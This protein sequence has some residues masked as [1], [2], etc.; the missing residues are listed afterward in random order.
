MDSFNAELRWRAEDVSPLLA[1]GT[2]SGTETVKRAETQVRA[3]GSLCLCV[4]TES[5]SP[6][7]SVTCTGASSADN[8]LLGWGRGGEMWEPPYGPQVSM[9]DNEGRDL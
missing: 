3:A 4:S 2:G 7:G 6:L 8:R 1:S 9:A 5:V